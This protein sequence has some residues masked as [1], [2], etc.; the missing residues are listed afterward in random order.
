MSAS[1]ESETTNRCWQASE[2]EFQPVVV[3]MSALPKALPLSS[4]FIRLLEQPEGWPPVSVVLAL[5]QE[6]A[7]CSKKAWPVS[8]PT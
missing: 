3:S 1:R 4:V 5:T 2:L 8:Q 6:G 7:S